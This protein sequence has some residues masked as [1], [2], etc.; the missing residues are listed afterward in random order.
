MCVCVCV[1]VKDQ[2]VGSVFF[3]TAAWVVNP[4]EL[5]L[6]HT[7]VLKKLHVPSSYTLSKSQAPLFHC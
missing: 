3:S 6:A 7:E 5:H 2:R 1:C 4:Y